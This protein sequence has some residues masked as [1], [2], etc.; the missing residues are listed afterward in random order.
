MLFSVVHRTSYRYASA[1]SLSHHTAHLRPLDLPYQTCRSHQL[2]ISPLPTSVEE[3]RDYFGNGV[4]AFNI[5]QPHR[6]L[7]V[8]ATSEVEV[9]ARERPDY[10]L[11]RGWEEV[12]TEVA[13]TRTPGALHATEFLFPSPSIDITASVIAFARVS[14]I[15]GRSVLEAAL[16]L[17][18]RIFEEFTFDSQ[19]TTISTAPAEVL[20]LKR[21]VCQDFAHLAIACC[22]AMGVP[23]RYISGYLETQPPRG[24]PRLVGADASHAWLSV[25]GGGGDWVDIDPTNDVL[26]GIGHIALAIGRDYRDVSPL[27]GIIIGGGEHDMD[28]G[29]DVERL[30]I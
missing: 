3:D 19:A 8:E 22:R 23:A 7:I 30:L 14:F 5:T 18:H 17:N 29:V 9:S 27:R 12:A 21:G 25:Y 10:L 2:A 1:V 11:D 28:V 26:A 13:T 15:P 24:Q 6:E 4:A 16:D 20:T